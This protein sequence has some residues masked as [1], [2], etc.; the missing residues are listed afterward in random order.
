MKKSQNIKTKLRESTYQD[1]CTLKSKDI[2]NLANTKLPW[3]GYNLL[4]LGLRGKSGYDFVLFFPFPFLFKSS[5]WRINISLVNVPT[6]GQ[7]SSSE[8]LNTSYSK[9]IWWI[10]TLS[11][12]F[13]SCHF[14]LHHGSLTTRFRRQLLPL[15]LQGLTQWSFGDQEPFSKALTLDMS[16]RSGKTL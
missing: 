12:L 10:S 9:I 6:S 2:M 4:T 7:S 13:E 5:A 1:S 8:I 15:H 16:I 11:I 3:M 14:F